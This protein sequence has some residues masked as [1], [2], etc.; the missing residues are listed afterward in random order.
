M[1]LDRRDRPRSRFHLAW[2]LLYSALRA[3]A[4]HANSFYTAFGIF[5]VAGAVLAIFGTW[6][7]VQ[8]ADTVTEGETQAFDEAVLTWMSQHRIEWIERSLLEITALGDGVVVM[9]IAAVAALF[10]FITKHR[11]SAFLLL[12]A[13]AG[14]LVLNAVLKQ[15]FARPRPSVF[16]RLDQVYTTS[17]PSGHAMT[18]AIVYATVAYLAARLETR[19]WMRF[20]TMGVA[21]LLI[22][23]ICLSRLYLG[24]HYPSDVLAGLVIGFAWAGFCVSGLE[25][26]RVFAERFGKKRVLE[27]QEKDLGRGERRAAGLET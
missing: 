26:A 18:A 8:L 1:T 2:D 20:V 14:G 17:F 4:R 22:A 16:E 13:T 27:Q 11:Y 19:R 24:V 5:L 3:I 7:F 10:L 6:A 25:A 9:V 12:F 21:L 15:S 23:L